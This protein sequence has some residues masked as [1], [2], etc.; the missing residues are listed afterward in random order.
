MTSIALNEHDSAKPDTTQK[1]ST[2]IVWQSADVGRM[3]VTGYGGSMIKP[4]F[5]LRYA[6]ELFLSEYLRFYVNMPDLIMKQKARP[7][8]RIRLHIMQWTYQL[9]NVQPPITED[10][11]IKIHAWIEQH[12]FDLIDK[13]VIRHSES[14]SGASHDKESKCKH[15]QLQSPESHTNSFTFLWQL[16]KRRNWKQ[17]CSIC[18]KDENIGTACTCGHTEIVMF[19]PCGHAVCVKPCFQQLM[20][21]ENNKL[22]EAR[23]NKK[24]KLKPRQVELADAEDKSKPKEQFIIADSVNVDLSTEDDSP[25][26]ACP[27]CR[28]GVYQTFQTENVRIPY[29]MDWVTHC[30]SKSSENDPSTSQSSSENKSSEHGQSSSQSSGETEGQSSESF[31]LPLGLWIQQCLSDLGLA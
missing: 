15:K 19:Q 17:N 29:H 20:N 1:L 16:A 3:T 28:Q 21:M 10:A 12:I 9:G 4:A 31:S 6:M 13:E 8:G 30:E 2:S 24:I 18:L 26:F 7:C 5:S 27:V 23:T 22:S 14:P 25:L 11:C